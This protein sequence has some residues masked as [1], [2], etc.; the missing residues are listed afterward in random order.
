MVTYSLG[1]DIKVG[2]ETKETKFKKESIHF[3]IPNPGIL[4]EAIEV[5]LLEV[6]KVGGTL[7]KCI[8]FSHVNLFLQI[9]MQESI[10]WHPFDGT[11]ININM[12]YQEQVG[13][14]SFW[15]WGKMFHYIG[16]NTLYL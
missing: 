5:F 8:R 16:V 12:Q 15:K 13:W 9:P 7:K 4:I 10:L 1:I 3:S 11:P 6:D 2:V 14:N